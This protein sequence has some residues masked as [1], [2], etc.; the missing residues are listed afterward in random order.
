MERGGKQEMSKNK[1]LQTQEFYL[2]NKRLFP[3]GNSSR[4]FFRNYR[5]SFGNLAGT[6]CLVDTFFFLTAE[7]SITA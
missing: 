7:K 3:N 4:E 2:L 1:L 5:E 6:L